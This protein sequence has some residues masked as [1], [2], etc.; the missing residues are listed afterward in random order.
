MLDSNENVESKMIEIPVVYGLVEVLLGE[1]AANSWR[2]IEE[3]N[4]HLE[5]REMLSRK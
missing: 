4:Q 1:K 5:L 3:I 2:D